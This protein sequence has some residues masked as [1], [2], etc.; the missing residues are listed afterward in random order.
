M[1]MLAVEVR[2]DL[3]FGFDNITNNDAGD[4][5]I[6]EAQLF[7]T[8]SDFGAGQVLFSFTNI[9]PDASSITDVYFD[10]GTLLGIAF[11]IDADDN[12]GD[13]GVDFTQD[14]SPPDLPG[15]NNL[16]PPFE[17]TAG[18]LADAD[19]PPSSNGVN[20]GESLGIVFDLM[21]GGT[22]ADVISELNSAELRI[23]IH[24]QGFAGGGS[25]SFV[26]PPVPIPAP[27]AV[28]L[29]ALGLGAVA[30]IKR[31]S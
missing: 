22:L 11:L 16:L 20:P 23:G 31:R 5:V 3:T 1:S 4:A 18:F 10:D 6:G 28:A 14:G 7:V 29:A 12:G 13:L 25:E 19:S 21:G 30:W 17:V 15:G 9:G 27:G 2:A 26:N 8:V 24:V